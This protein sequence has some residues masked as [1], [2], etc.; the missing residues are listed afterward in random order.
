MQDLQAGSPHGTSVWCQPGE[1]FNTWSHLAALPVGLAASVVLIC[2]TVAG[3]DARKIVGAV[4]FGLSLAALFGA[5]ALF[6]GCTGVRKRFWQRVDH[7]CIYLLIAGSHTPFALMAPPGLWAWLLLG[8]VWGLA[9]QGA[10]RALGFDSPPR[11]FL[12]ISLGWLSLGS[13]VPVAFRHGAQT[14]AWL[15]AGGLL[16]SAGTVFYRRLASTRHAHGIWHLFVVAGSACHTVAI[17]GL[18]A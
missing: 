11:L 14:L 7:A 1:R 5:S 2:E 6:H 10:I 16:Y 17:A 18:L 13:A 3:G 4:V 15:L 12:Y 8:G 9:F